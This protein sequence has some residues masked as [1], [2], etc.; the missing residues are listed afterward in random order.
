MGDA[1]VTALVKLCHGVQKALENVK[2][3]RSDRDELLA[4]VN[5]LK[6][7]LQGLDELTGVE[8]EFVQRSLKDTQVF[9][10]KW[11]ELEAPG[12]QGIVSKGKAAIARDSN[13]IAVERLHRR[14]SNCLASL[15][16]PS[17]EMKAHICQSVHPN[18]AAPGNTVG[19]WIR[20]ACVTRIR[21][22]AALGARE[23]FTKDGSATK[24]MSQ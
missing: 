2:E 11:A 24:W 20:P 18:L 1:V 8:F 15:A 22:W 7:K 19:R 13:K 14:L 3:T 10:E 12:M 6:S 16:V 9:A 4:V 21:S 23:S 5:L 17:P